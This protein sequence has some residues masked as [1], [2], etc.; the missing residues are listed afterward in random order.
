[1]A[2]EIDAGKYR[3]RI[4]LVHA[5]TDG[6]R[7]TFGARQ[8]EGEQ[9]TQVRAAKEDWGG[10]ETDEFGRETAEVTT[11]FF[12]RWRANVDSTMQV[13]HG[14]ERYDIKSVLDF[15][16]TKRELVLFCKKVQ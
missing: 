7:D 16:G 12:I 11:R 13:W 1:M 10:S 3:H 5:P 14:D 8:G 4:T 2:K 6:S 9:D 15:D